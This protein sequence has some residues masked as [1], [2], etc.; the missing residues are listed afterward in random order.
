VS[1]VHVRDVLDAMAKRHPGL[2]ERFGGHA[3]AAGMTLRAAH[4][5]DFEHAFADEVARR[6]DIDELTGDLHTDGE[7]EAREFEPATAHALR[8]GG[9]WGAGFPEPLFDGRFGVVDTRIVAERHLKLR[10]RV[11]SGP[12]V[13]AIVFRHFDQRDPT[14]VRAGDAVEL[15]YRVGLDDYGGTSRIQLVA[16]WL[17]TPGAPGP[18]A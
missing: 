4:L 10:V 1:G 3:M 14:V 8:E 5:A 11:P 17:G 18:H 12:F 6:L 2:L 13:D 16:E 9:P 15:A 7:L